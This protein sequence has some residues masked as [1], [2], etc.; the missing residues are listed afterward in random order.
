M[1]S[2]SISSWSPLL[3]MVMCSRFKRI[4]DRESASTLSLIHLSSATVP[5]NIEAAHLSEEGIR[6]LKRQDE[7]HVPF[8][9]A[10]SQHARGGPKSCVAP[11]MFWEQPL[12]HFEKV[13]R[14]ALHSSQF[15]QPK[16]RSGDVVVSDSLAVHLDF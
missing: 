6:L 14:I 2:Y 1:S 4:E 13:P 7:I 3:Q 16:V 10:K 15:H 5:N 12:L 8:R 11:A 9:V